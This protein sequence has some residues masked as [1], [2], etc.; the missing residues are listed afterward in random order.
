MIRRGKMSPQVERCPNYGLLAAV[1]PISIAF[2]AVAS[3]GLPLSKADGRD[4]RAEELAEMVVPHTY[5]DSQEDTGTRAS[6]P[7][8][9]FGLRNE[10]NTLAHD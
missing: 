9:W 8:Y 4:F 6:V 1:A 2:F 5:G 10:A 3:F 7:A